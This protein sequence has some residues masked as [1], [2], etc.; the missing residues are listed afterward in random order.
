MIRVLGA[1]FQGM[2][3]VPEVIV[4]R[5]CGLRVLGFAIMTNLCVPGVSTNHEEVTDVCG[6]VGS[7]LVPVLRDALP[8]LLKEV[9][10]S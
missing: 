3:T 7:V 6:K 4:A 2:S 9:T 10:S 1:Q 5:H 8:L